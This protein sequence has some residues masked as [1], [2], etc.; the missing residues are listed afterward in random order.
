MNK[1]A[2]QNRTIVNPEMLFGRQDL[3][4]SLINSARRNEN[5][6]IVGVRRFGKTSLLKS[7]V[8]AMKSDSSFPVYPVF[9]DF[10]SMSET[11]TDVAYRYMISELLAS[12][13]SD[14]INTDAYPIYNIS[15]CPS[16]EWECIMDQLKDLSGFRLHKSLENLIR[17]FSDLMGK[18]IL[19]MIDEYEFLFQETLD[20]PEGFMRLRNLGA[21]IDDKDRRFFSFWLVGS[22]TW[23]KLRDIV[24]PGSGPANTITNH[25]YVTPLDKESFKDW[26][27]NEVKK[28]DEE[29]RG[30][31][32]DK[33]DFAY[34][35]TGGV[36]FYGI[37]IA[38]KLINK[39][40]PSHSVLS[41]SFDEL[42][43]RGLQHDEV[44]ILDKMSK[45]PLNEYNQKIIELSEL[46]LIEKKHKNS[47]GI[48][49]G[50][51]RDY[52]IAHNNNK[53]N[54]AS[55]DKFQKIVTDIKGL[56]R[57]IN[58]TRNNKKGNFIF[59]PVND[60]T[61]WEENLQNKCSSPKE[62]DVFINAMYLTF[63]ER[64]KENNTGDLLPKQYRGGQFARCL[65][66]ARHGVD[67]AMDTFV[68]L[69]GQLTRTEMLKIVNGHENE[70]YTREDFLNFQFNFLKLFKEELNNMLLFV[71]KN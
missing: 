1:V 11:G 42:T 36:P 44:A 70:P 34:E 38:E 22:I 51:L 65:G 56:I 63:F 55:N 39:E 46:G 33:L 64:A 19:F 32:T 9:L 61:Y 10:K 50:M 4:V 71:Q 66:T 69:P 13:F 6:N 29:V 67:H 17:F 3:M 26:W 49:I 30:F 25:V 47:Y 27:Q 52:F 48:K 24:G 35:S 12:L 43:K 45:G 37:K 7:L 57:T 18:S 5:V 28:A 2:F 68:S 14:G 54:D 16:D 20:K 59:K 31:L 40:L 53:S 62:F 15:V 60:S 8:T 58:S 23:G 41:V 21:A